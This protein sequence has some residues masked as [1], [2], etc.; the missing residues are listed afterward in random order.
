MPE[1]VGSI[2]RVC[3]CEPQKLEQHEESRGRVLRCTT[4]GAEAVSLAGGLPDVLRDRTSY[5]VSVQLTPALL[6]RFIHLLKEKTGRSTP[7]LMAMAREGA[8]LVLEN[9]TARH[10]HYELSDLLADGLPVEVTPPYPHPLSPS[11]GRKRP[12]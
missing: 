3:A 2:D 1:S 5:R 8:T 11:K 7:E 10:F 9:R 12:S 4:C 6:K